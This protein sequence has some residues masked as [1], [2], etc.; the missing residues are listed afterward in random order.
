MILEANPPEAADRHGPG[1]RNVML[2]FSHFTA[3]GKVI[4]WHAGSKTRTHGCPR[5]S[6][7]D[8]AAAWNHSDGSATTHGRRIAVV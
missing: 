3:W 1:R 6:R 7:S 2:N 5:R 8:S 4:C